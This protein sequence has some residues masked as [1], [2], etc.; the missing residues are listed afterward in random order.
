[1]W[2]QLNGKKKVIIP[3]TVVVAI[4]IPLLLLQF[5]FNGRVIAS[6][7][8]IGTHTTA[9]MDLKEIPA[10]IARLENNDEHL[11]ED[12]SRIQSSVETIESDIKQI[13]LIVTEK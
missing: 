10:Q 11:K 3:A 8:I 6:E 13:L 7:V 1:M 9:I 5:N 2:K 12:I 4:I